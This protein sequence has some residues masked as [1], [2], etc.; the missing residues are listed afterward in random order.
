MTLPTFALERNQSLWENHVTHNLTESGLHPHALA[1]VLSP[2]EL[3]EVMSLPLGYGYT[4]GDPELKARIASLYPGAGAANVLVTN[5]SAEANFV[6]MWSLLQPGDEIVYM[7]PN[8]MQIHGIAQ[9]LGVTVRPWPLRQ[10]LGWQPDLD[11]L[12][13]L[14]SDRTRAIVICNPNNP[15]GAVLPPETQRAI[16][17]IAEAHDLWVHSDEIYRGSELEGDE[18][19]SFAGFSSRGIVVSG[20]SKALGFPG[21]RL[22]WIVAPAALIEECWRRHDYTSISTS[23]ISQYAA[24]RILAPGTR[25]RLLQRGREHLRRNLALVEQ[26]VDGYQGRLTLTRPQAG[27]MAFIGYDAA[28]DSQGL[29]DHLRSECDVFLVAGTWFGMEGYLRIGI[30]VTHETLETGLNRID[31]VLKKLLGVGP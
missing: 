29:V 6:A 25:E 22:G 31:P 14:I 19:P 4:D 28:L 2:E 27:G 7:V 17:A 18:G 8:Y 20:L 24:V 16:A 3:T 1:D 11:E 23:I 13:R 26:W 15:T 5:G 12:E 30:G 10:A 21:L 9:A